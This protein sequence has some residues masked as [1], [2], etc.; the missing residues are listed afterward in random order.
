MRFT[1]SR[2]AYSV[3]AVALYLRSSHWE[4]RRCL[5]ESVQWF[6]DPS[7]NVKV[8]SKS[9]EAF[10]RPGAC[11][12][13]G[14]FPQRRTAASLENGY[15][16]PWAAGMDHYSVEE[17]RLAEAVIAALSKGI[18]CVAGRCFPGHNLCREGSG[19]FWRGPA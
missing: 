13:A 15:P 19:E 8:A 5:L 3:I 11:R 2:V 18:L 16:V 7:V 4:V 17:L 9:G 1:G 6:G 10:G 12:G 14:A